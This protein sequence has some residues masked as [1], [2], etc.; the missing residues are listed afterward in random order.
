M[1]GVY[2][3]T[4]GRRRSAKSKA[5]SPGHAVIVHLDR[6]TVRAEAEQYD[7][8]SIETE[9][10]SILDAQGLGEYDGNET[11][12]GGATL[13]MYG[14]DGERL[15]RGIE[16]ALRAYPLCRKARVLI[17]P[18]PPGTPPREVRL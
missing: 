14:S 10:Q 6:G 15:F 9:L 5:L 4:A 11:G 2:R 18:G 17:R 16:A 3:F 1:E 13:F 8:S 12:D 7:L